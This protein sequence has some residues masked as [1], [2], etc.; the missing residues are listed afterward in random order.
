VSS[1]DSEGTSADEIANSAEDLSLVAREVRDSTTVLKVLGV[2]EKNGA[3]GLVANSGAGVAN[4]SGSESGTLRVTS[5][6]ELRVGALGVGQV[7]EANHLGDG[8]RSG[9]ARHEVTG[10]GG[11]VGAADTLDPDVVGTVLA[12]ESVTKRR[13]KSSLDVVRY[14]KCLEVIYGFCLPSYPAQ[15]YH[16]RRRGWPWGNYWSCPAR[17]RSWSRSGIG[18]QQEP[19]FEH[20]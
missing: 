16:E 15:W 19:R 13:A 11:V 10:D 1:S 3:H 6:N 14:L 4:G 2:S 9:S 17:A 18:E 12:L 7:Q 8:L 5:S 20:R